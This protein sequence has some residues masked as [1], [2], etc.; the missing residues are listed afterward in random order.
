[1]TDAESDDKTCGFDMDMAEFIDNLTSSTSHPTNYAGAIKKKQARLATNATSPE[2][3]MFE[4]L[5][6]LNE[7]ISHHLNDPSF[8]AMQENTTNIACD[9]I[10]DMYVKYCADEYSMGVSENK[11]IESVDSI[12]QLRTTSYA[13]VQTIQQTGVN[14]LLHVLFDSGS[15]KTLI[16]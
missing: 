9:E 10:V 1:M 14:C 6:N 3:G 8:L 13:I 16:K 2:A 15:D 11:V 5:V 7:P 4:I 12:L